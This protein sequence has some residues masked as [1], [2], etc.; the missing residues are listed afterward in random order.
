MCFYAM[1]FRHNDLVQ[2]VWLLDSINACKL[3]ISSPWPPGGFPMS[4]WLAIFWTALY[5]GIPSRQLSMLWSWMERIL[6][7]STYSSSLCADRR[8]CPW[9]TS[10]Q[11]G[12]LKIPVNIP[13]HSLLLC[14]ALSA[15]HPWHSSLQSLSPASNVAVWLDPDVDE[16]VAGVLEMYQACVARLEHISI[17]LLMQDPGNFDWHRLGGAEHSEA[18]QANY[19]IWVSDSCWPKM[20]TPAPLNLHSSQSGTHL[21]CCAPHSDVSCNSKSFVDAVPAV[22]SKY[23]IKAVRE[24]MWQT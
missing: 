13:F 4:S 15:E 16:F 9:K 19:H 3:P 8:P 14:G 11:S 22:V 20:C 21:H 7:E 2:G 12:Q 24:N 1:P 5:A 6:H 17:T 23:F 10:S 18:H